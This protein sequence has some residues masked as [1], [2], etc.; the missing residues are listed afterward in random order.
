MSVLEIN[1]WTLA[2]SSVACDEATEGD[3]LP[4]WLAIVW[5]RAQETFEGIVAHF[6]GESGEWN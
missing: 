2:W 6:G 4:S 3:Y 5:C 1:L